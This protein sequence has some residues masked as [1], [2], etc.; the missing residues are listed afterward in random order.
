VGRQ[1]LQS[2]ENSVAY[3]ERKLARKA[4]FPLATTPESQPNPQPVEAFKQGSQAA[5]GS[6]TTANAEPLCSASP[7]FIEDAPAGVDGIPEPGLPYPSLSSIALAQLTANRANAQSC[8]GPKTEAG[9]ATSS[10]NRTTHGLARH[11]GVF[12]LL[13]SEDP[14]GFEAL[15]ASLAAEHD[16]STETES[17]LINSMAESHW[18]AN[19][20]LALQNTCFDP[21]TG[22][23]AE[24]QMF[25]LYLRYQTTHTRAFHKSLNDFL[26]LRAEKRKT[27]NGFE[28]QARQQEELRLKNERHQ[29]KKETHYWEVLKKDA[30]TCFRIGQNVSQNRKAAAA[31][32]GFE[33]QYNAEL[34]KHNLRQ[35]FCRGTASAA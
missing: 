31:D 19:R 3:K 21:Q 29:M 15:K 2:F 26:K 12:I 32:P 17:I 35:D 11:N 28:A 33:A 18:L 16:P 7:A 14:N 27:E 6:A 20:A 13:P 22:H 34:A 9:R 8:T 4:G 25:S 10:Q 5:P 23:I 30:E 24:A 1:F